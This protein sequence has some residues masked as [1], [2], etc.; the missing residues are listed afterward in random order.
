ML[1]AC[2]T[3]GAS[4]K[5]FGLVHA[6]GIQDG[7][8]YQIR[9]YLSCGHQAA[10][11]NNQRLHDSQSRK[12]SGGLQAGMPKNSSA[13]KDMRIDHAFAALM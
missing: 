13:A 12:H 4:C 2:L 7:T 8:R 10:V 6:Y 5:R 3:V 9:L 1:I 11:V